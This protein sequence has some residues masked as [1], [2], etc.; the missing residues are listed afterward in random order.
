VVVAPDGTFA[1]FTIVW[2]DD[3]NQIGLFEPVGCHPE[4]Q[5]RGLASAVML[6]GMRRLQQAGATVAHVLS[7]A[8]DSPGAHLY[9]A[10]GFEAV[11][12]IY[13]WEKQI[14]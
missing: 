4:H 11:D 8:D 2:L 5:R 9:R 3:A 13:I 1:A 7:A 10:L 12:R 14:N 6:E